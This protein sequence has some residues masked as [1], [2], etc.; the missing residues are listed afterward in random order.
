[1]STVTNNTG[2]GV[3]IQDMRSK[4]RISNET[5]IADNKFGAGI[6][7]YRGAGEVIINGTVIQNNADAGVNITYSGG[8]QLINN[9][10][11]IGNK[12]YGMITEYIKFNRTRIEHENRMQVVRARF[13]ENELVALRMGNYC[14]GGQIKVNESFFGF[15]YDDA[16]EYLSC[17]VSTQFKNKVIIEYNEFDHN[18]RHAIIM[19]PL[20]NMEGIITN[21]SFTNHY[22][23]C[24]RIDNGYDLLLSRW[25]RDFPVS[26]KIFE[27]KFTN[28]SGRYAVNFHLTQNSAIQ[29]LICKFNHFENNEI[30]NSFPY[31]NP[32]S[33]ANAVAVISSSNIKFRRNILNNPLS[34]WEIAT[35]LTDPSATIDASENY[36][37]FEI[38]RAND[39]EAVFNNIFDQVIIIK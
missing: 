32:R 35:H 3:N 12:G 1:M 5:L 27:N 8:F 2:Y 9:T 10:E 6:R 28:N 17:N 19:Q 16:F 13:V 34:I 11:F 20:L 14:K 7:I 33:R 23:A 37:G 24:F 30:K 4:V 22:L 26:L 31:L 36:W 38:L 21:N 25:Y 15:N 18:H 39:F 29:E